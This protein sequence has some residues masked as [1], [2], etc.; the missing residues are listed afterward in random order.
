MNSAARSWLWGE[1]FLPWAVLALLLVYTYVELFYMPYIGFTFVLATGEVTAVFV[2]NAPDA[3]LQSGDRL[4]QVGGVPWAAYR[5]AVRRPLFQAVKTGEVLPIR[6]ERA[7]RPRLIIWS[8]PGP[9]RGEI[10]QRLVNTWWLAYF[11]WLA[12]TATVVLV[13]PKDT[14]WRLLI[15]FYY[16]TAIWLVTGNTS[17]WHVWESA[18][19]LRVTGWLLLPVCWHLHWVLPRPLAQTPPWLWPLGYGLSWLAALLQGAE[20]LPPQA[21]LSGFLLALVGSVVLLLVHLATQPAERQGLRLLL[22]AILLTVLAL[23]S[24]SIAQVLAVAPRFSY[25]ALL[26]LP[27]LPLAY[28]YTTYRYRLGG[29]AVRANRLIVLYLFLTLLG[30][31]MTLLVV[32]LMLWL[33]FPGKDLLITLLATFLT[34][35]VTV[36]GFAPFQQWVERHLLGIHLPATHL[37]ESYAA[38]ITTCLDLSDLVHTLRQEVL[39]SLLVRES[40]L[41][42]LNGADRLATVYSEGVAAQALPTADRLPMLLARQG[43][44]Q[45]PALC[46][47]EGLASADW[48]RLVL[49]LRANNRLMGLWLLGRRDPDNFYAQ[50]EIVRFQALADQTAIALTNIDQAAQLRA[51]HKAGIDRHETE[52][53]HL[54]HVL[55]DEVLQALAVLSMHLD[56]A[57]ASPHFDAVYQRLTMRIRQLITGL[58]PAMMTYGLYA[59]LAELNEDLAERAGAAVVVQFKMTPG[60]ARYPTRVEEHL[61]R[62]VQQAC[63]NALRHAHAQT[64]TL[65]GHCAADGVAIMVTDDG[66]GFAIDP[67]FAVTTLLADKHFGLVGMYERADLIGATVQIES[68]LGHGTQVRVGW[69]GQGNTPCPADAALPS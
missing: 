1:R 7:G 48:V 3:D 69:Q 53:T 14:R 62:I 17:R 51:L 5:Q 29:L 31:I 47:K 33:T 22:G 16:L 8:I 24:A 12:G 38:R 26:T 2:Q 46:D 58:R 11:F 27:L 59:A 28:F 36:F 65:T 19:L 66:V 21:Y 18:I 39:P 10:W 61:F 63:E 52:R 50:A 55:H 42:R 54:A 9:T 60:T 25:G 43:T 6:V 4:L 15:A 23:S 49:P 57:A 20:W 67:P 40:A 37:L 45:T 34:A 30:V 13:R 32:L 56:D 35:I 44:V 64:I 68:A 41:V